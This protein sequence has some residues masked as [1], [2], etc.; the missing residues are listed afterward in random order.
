MPSRLN[1]GPD[2]LVKAYGRALLAEGC[3]PAG[4]APDIW[5]LNLVY[6]TGPVRDARALTKLIAARREAY[7]TDLRVTD[8]QLVRWHHTNTGMAPAVLT[9]VKPPQPSQ[10]I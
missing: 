9:S 2:D 8:I 5:Y 3:G 4:R 1:T 7:V 10:T 6:F